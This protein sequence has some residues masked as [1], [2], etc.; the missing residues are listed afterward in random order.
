MSGDIDMGSKKIINVSAPINAAD[1]ANKKYVDDGL[2]T[3][4]NVSDFNTFK[5][6]NSL[7]IEE[8]KKAGT[9]AQE[10]IS[11]SILPKF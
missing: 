2:A 11:E 10:T 5:T 8:A 4:V 9:D 3:K 1:A 7:A 6:A